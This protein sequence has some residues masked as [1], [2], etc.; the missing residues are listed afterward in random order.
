MYLEK[1]SYQKKKSTLKKLVFIPVF[2]AIVSVLGLLIFIGFLST[3]TGFNSAKKFTIPEGYS[4]IQTGILLEENDIIRS[5]K[6]FRILAQ[7]E[8]VSVKAGTYLFDVPISLATVIERLQTSNYGDIDDSVTLLEGMT[9]ADISDV[10]DK[11]INDFD[12]DLF[13]ERTVDKE[14]YL[15]PDTYQFL[16]DTSM[17][18]I[19]ETLLDTFENKT[20]TIRENLD[21]E[22]DFNDV[23][24]MASIIE[25]EAG[26]SRDEQKIVSGILWKRIAEGMLLQVDAPFVYARGKGSAELSISDLR[27]DGPY[28]TYTRK[29]LTPTAIGNPGLSALNAAADP[30]SSPYYFYLHG[31]DG[32]IHYGVNHNDHINNKNK[33]LR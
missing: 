23:V 27:T 24:I 9:N 7:W 28:N 13:I 29:G 14:G 15:F 16:P 26:P 18:K 1:D 22:K 21:P 5:N 2:F 31:N 3:P 6:L 20:R 11:K 10:L 12:Q 17:E 19:I 25:K 8:G 32:R 33:Y 4:I 30:V